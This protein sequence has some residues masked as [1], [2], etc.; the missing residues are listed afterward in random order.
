MFTPMFCIESI[1]N[2]KKVVTDQLFKDP[3]LNKAAHAY[4]DAQ[5]QFAKMT[6]ITPSRWLS[7]L[8]D[9]LVNICFQ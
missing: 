2:A 3:A 1:Q 4:I 6:V 7:I 5:T 9:Q 8:L